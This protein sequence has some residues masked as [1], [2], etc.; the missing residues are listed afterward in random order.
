MKIFNLA[1]YNFLRLFGPR[2]V[3][4]YFRYSLRFV[5][6]WWISDI[7]M[8]IYTDGG[9]QR[10]PPHREY[11]II[12]PNH[13]LKCSWISTFFALFTSQIM[14]KGCNAL[15]ETYPSTYNKDP[16]CFVYFDL[17]FERN[18]FPQKMFTTLE[19]IKMRKPT[20]EVFGNLIHFISTPIILISLVNGCHVYAFVVC[21]Y[22]HEESI[23]S[24]WIMRLDV[25][26]KLFYATLGSIQ[27]RPELSH[28]P[29]KM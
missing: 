24:I 5:S 13:I 9:R 15:S 29:E 21:I 2:T 17:L 11:I 6:F 12:F 27:L 1:H 26:I 16:F 18:S 20:E 4:C 7:Y 14:W 22:L 19:W 3:I 25:W 28:P 8:Y 10:Y 23:H